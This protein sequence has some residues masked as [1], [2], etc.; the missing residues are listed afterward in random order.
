MRSQANGW[1]AGFGPEISMIPV[2]ETLRARRHAEG[3]PEVELM[4]LFN[5]DIR[6]QE[7]QVLTRHAQMRSHETCR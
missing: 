7:K 3:R 4:P 6:F 2:L 5:G 1:S